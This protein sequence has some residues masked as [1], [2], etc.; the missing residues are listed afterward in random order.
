MKTQPNPDRFIV[1]AAFDGEDATRV[2][3]AGA[4]FAAEIEGG[5]LHLVHAIGKLPVGTAAKDSAL[6]EGRHRLELAGVAAGKIYTPTIFG[7]LAVGPAASEILVVADEIEADLIVV[8]AMGRRADD[9]A[10]I[11][12][13][14]DRIVRHASC[15]VLVVR[16]K[17]YHPAIEPPCPDCVEVRETSHGAS[18][19]CA[20][21]GSKH[22]HGHAMYEYPESFALGSSIIRPE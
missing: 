2:I 16:D 20:R 13:V 21:H 12:S 18:M 14:A 10:H 3:D 4:R 8:G 11:G 1:L 5:E 22:P 9:L 19:W 17:G 15:P 7:H 6:A